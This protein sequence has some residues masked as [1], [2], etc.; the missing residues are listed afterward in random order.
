MHK[1]HRSLQRHNL[2][3]QFQSALGQAPEIIS[4]LLTIVIMSPTKLVVGP[5]WGSTKPSV[6][7]GLKGAAPD[8]RRAVVA[9]F[10]SGLGTT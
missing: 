6:S 2:G 3:T 1:I 9:L 10:T 4:A 5:L 7:S 8:G